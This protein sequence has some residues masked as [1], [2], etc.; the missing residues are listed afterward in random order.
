MKVTLGKYKTND[1]PRHISVHIDPWD[2]WNTDETLAHIIVPMLR[3]VKAQKEGVPGKILSDEY[4]AITT[5]DEYYAESSN[6]LLHRRANVL[7]E[8]NMAKWDEILDHMIWA[9][10]QKTLDWEEQFYGDI[11]SHAY[12]QHLSR[13]EE[14]FA[15]F[16]KHY[17]DLWT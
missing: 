5:C 4:L 6:G 2:T 3:Q 9:F 16:G 1:K 17:S 13:M 14:G 7:F 10:E 11:N 8:Q 15:L 12:K